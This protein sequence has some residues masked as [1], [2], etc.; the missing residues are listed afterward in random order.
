[1]AGYDDKS[2]TDVEADLAVLLDLGLTNTSTMVDLGAGTGALAV[3]AAPHCRRVVGVDVSPAMLATARRRAQA[4]GA[5]NVEF[6]E[7]GFLT[8]EH[9][10]D[11][12]DIVTSR[13]AFHHLPDFWKA[14]ALGR[15]AGLLR[16]GGAL[17]VRD[18]FYSFE[19]PDTAARFEAWFDNA[20]DNPAVGWTREELEEHV[21]G[22]HSTFTWLFEPMLEHAGF[23]ITERMYA[24]S[25][26][27]A[28]Y[29][30]IRR[31]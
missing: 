15:V 2:G 4:Q 9:L 28:T 19:P 8:Y 17:R 18:L 31:A 1:V 20:V 27:Y 30:C 25:G 16:I 12:A 7:A 29:T 5:S 23:E 24:P 13:H 14:V 10:G 22:E 21:R 26:T 6:V 11:P 3:A